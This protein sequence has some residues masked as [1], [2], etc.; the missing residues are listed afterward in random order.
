MEAGRVMGVDDEEGPE[1]LHGGIDRR[2]VPLVVR[3]ATYKGGGRGLV[4][5]V[6]AAPNARFACHRQ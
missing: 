1:A 4:P 3:C 6:N 2:A 5:G